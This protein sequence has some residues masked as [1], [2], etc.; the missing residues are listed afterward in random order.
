MLGIYPEVPLMGTYS[1]IF[2]AVFNLLV[3]VERGPWGKRQHKHPKHSYGQ[4]FINMCAFLF[5][6]S[7]K[8]NKSDIQDQKSRNKN[9]MPFFVNFKNID[10][11]DYM[12]KDRQLKQ[13]L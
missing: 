5:H 12:M 3:V 11:Y 6:L 4:Q 7:A 8:L 1:L 13:S 10:Y 9:M 2:T